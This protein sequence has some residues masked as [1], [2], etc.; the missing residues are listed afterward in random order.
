IDA[1]FF[2]GRSTTSTEDVKQHYKTQGFNPVSV[3]SKELTTAVKETF[4]TVNPPRKFRIESFLLFAF[5]LG[6]LVGTAYRGSVNGAGLYV[7][8]LVSCVFAALSTL[9][10]VAFRSRVDWGRGGALVCLLPA[11]IVAIGAAG[12]LWFYAGIGSIELPTV[13]VLAIVALVI[14]VVNTSVN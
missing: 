12:L 6:L 8:G 10:G 9:P 5:G 4:P 7:I 1:L 2:G 13:V 3:I 14:G 11:L